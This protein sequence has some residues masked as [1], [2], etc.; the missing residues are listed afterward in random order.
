MHAYLML[1]YAIVFL[2]FLIR[3]AFMCFYVLGRF[4]EALAYDII[5]PIH[6][7]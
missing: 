2:L 1:R 3:L 7:Y 5:T 6:L 4:L